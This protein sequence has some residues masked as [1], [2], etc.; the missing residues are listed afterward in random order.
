MNIRC[1]GI[2][3]SYDG[4]SALRD[5]NLQIQS[6]ELV[7]LL[8]PS[9]CGKTTLLR[10]MAGLLPMQQGQLFYGE[11]EITNWTPQKRN[12]AMVFQSYALFPHLSVAEN[13]AY[14]LKAKGHKKADIHSLVKS[15]LQKVQLIDL[16]NRMVQELSGGQQQRVALAR[17]LVLKPDVLL[18]DE[19]LSNLDE[20]LRINMR[21][22]IR[23]LQKE[24]GIS[25]VYV[26]HDQEEAMAIADRIVVMNEGRIQQIGTPREVYHQ[27]KNEFVAEFMGVSNM[28]EVRGEKRLFRPE[29][30]VLSSSG[31]HE[32]IVQWIEHL[33]GLEQVC[34]TTQYGDLIV[35]RFSRE[36]LSCEL[37]IGYPVRIDLLGDGQ[38][39]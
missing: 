38:K 7:A 27:P 1:K 23:L 10:I 17:A 2:N 36:S 19:P 12:T 29:Q 13:V 15:T 11:R 33:G 32:G 30:I 37:D 24:S 20:K 26:T 21:R 18:F 16:D 6:G 4:V 22:E 25:S 8:G 9:G 28:I 31:K 35:Q 14:G 34:V 5:L 3:F 39:I